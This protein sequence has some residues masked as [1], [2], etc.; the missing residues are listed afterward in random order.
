LTQRLSL[1]FP[2][3]TLIGFHLVSDGGIV[4]DLVCEVGVVR[5]RRLDELRT[6][7]EVVGG[8][9]D[10]SAVIAERADYLMNV[11]P[12]ADQKRLSSACR[13]CAKLDQRML[14]GADGFAE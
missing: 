5:E 2:A 9:F 10:A 12:S 7:S 11:E 8:I 14:F 3:G 1:A 13:P 4:V 6:D